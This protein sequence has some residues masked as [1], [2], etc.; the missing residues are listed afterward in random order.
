MAGL[1]LGPL[2]RYVDADS[3]TVWVETDGPCV[4]HVR[5]DDG[6]GGAQHTW[7]VAGHHYALVPVTGLTPGSE[8]PYRVLLDDTQEVW[9]LPD[10][11]FPASTIRTLPA[12]AQEPLHFAFG[13]C[14]WSATPSN[15]AHDPVG[16]DALDTL[17]ATLAAGSGRQRPDVLLLLGDQVYADQTSEATAQILAGRRDLTE[18]PWKQVADYE[19]YTYLYYESWLDPEVRWLLSTVPSCMIFDDHDVIDDWNTSAS[20]LTRMRATPWWRERILGGLMSYWVH[21]HLGNLSPA[22]LAADELYA[23]VQSVPDATELVREFAAGADADAAHARWSYRRDFGRVRLVMI[24]TRATR[25]LD[26]SNRAMLD[27]TEGEWLRQAVLD[28]RGSYDHLLLGSSLPW[29]LP[30][31]IHAGEGWNAALCAGERGPR[32]ARRSE[33]LRQ[34]A[35]LEHWSA[36]P[37]SFTALTE[38]IA[39]AGSGAHAPATVCVLSGDVHHAYVAEPHWRGAGPHPASRVLQLTCSPVHNSIPGSL[40]AGFRFG[41]SRSGRWLGKLLARHGRLPRPA[42]KWRRTGGPWFGNQLMTLT[43]AGRAAR[44][45]LD[46]TRREKQGGVRLVTVWRAALTDARVGGESGGAGGPA[47]GTE[48]PKSG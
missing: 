36:F 22:E 12:S 25:V 24:D 18:P 11:R 40:Q 21:Q 2:L 4:V 37:G 13:S 28:G 41:W 39:E 31:L 26:E 44:L 8:T 6:A 32:W 19:E 33:R 20:W 43:L 34:R 42:V 46:Q 27:K 15:A 38:L 1:R 23:Q 7:Q 5:C 48:R 9:P 45:A 17:A 3:A 16:P 29:L 35:D 47:A 30:H 14:R 10:S